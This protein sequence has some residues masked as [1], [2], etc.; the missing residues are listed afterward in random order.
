VVA[1]SVPEHLRGRVFAL[2]Y[3]GVRLSGV[4]SYAVGGVAR[5]ITTPRLV[6]VVAGGLGVLAGVALACSRPEPVVTGL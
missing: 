6:L 1:R 4:L 3:G 2:V 5:G